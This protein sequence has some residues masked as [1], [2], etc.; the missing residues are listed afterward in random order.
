[1]ASTPLSLPSLSSLFFLLLAITHIQA[2]S[3]SA[4]APSP[5]GPD[6]ITDILAEAKNYNFFIKLLTETQVGNQIN[7]QVNNSADGMTVFAPTDGAF[8]ALPPGYLNNLSTN[9][10]VLLVQ[11]HVLPKYY[12]LSDLQTVS[13]PVRTQANG[14]DGSNFG[15]YFS[16]S[17]NQVTVSTGIVETPVNNAL[18]KDS[19]LAVYQVDKVLMPKQFSEAKAPAPAPPNTTSPAAGTNKNST[20]SS[21]S[22]AAE[23]PSNDSGRLQ[24]RLGLVAGLGLL[25]MGLFS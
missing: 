20:R 2:Q 12:S 23:P 16:S 9:Q 1:M 8:S 25:C 7:T 11:Y 14:E 17:N 18:N 5:P 15:L 21:S 4:P 3:P 24:M 19:H 13:N 10:Q 22:S 6:N